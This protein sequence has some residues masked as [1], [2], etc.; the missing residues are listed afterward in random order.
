MNV[1]KKLEYNFKKYKNNNAFCINDINYTY[2]QLFI[3]VSQIRDIIQKNIPDQ[4]QIC[5]LFDYNDIETYATIIALWF[6]GK[7]YIPVSVSSPIERNSY[8][9]E[10]TSINFL[11]SSHSEENYIENFSVLSSNINSN[12][13]IKFKPYIIDESNLLYTIFTSGSTGLPKGVPI[14]LKNLNSLFSAMKFDE[15]HDIYPTDKCLQMFDLTFDYS[16]VTFL[17]PLLNGACVYTLPKDQI[18]Y[19]YI[20]KLINIYQLNYLIM[21]PS[22]INYL[23]PYFGEMNFKTVRYSCFGA[24][25]L[26]L[27]LVE[28]WKKCVPNAKI[29]NSYGPTENTVTSTYYDFNDYQNQ[30]SKNGIVAIGK[31]LKGIKTIILDTNN[32]IVKNGVEG[33]LCVSGNQVTVG[34]LNNTKKNKSSFIM[35]DYEGFN[36]KFYKTGDLCIKK[37]DETLIFIG[38]KDFQ[39]KI[40]GYRVELGEIEHHSKNFLKN[41]NISVIDIINKNNETEL[42]LII[43]NEEFDTKKLINY[44]KTKLPSY[45]IPTKIKFVK[46]LLYNSNGKIDNNKLKSLF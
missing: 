23:K 42:A 2:N 6:E 43:A 19:M 7:S 28:E 16:I 36:L 39:I 14:D 32:K 10:S 17:Y 24:A 33:E 15:R 46:E 1:L 13:L 29:Y 20:Y 41:N 3:K 26:P 34:Y 8:I 5:G 12:E 11:F 35:Y 30:I 31:P 22:I 25:P 37:D 38:R 9:F 45:M 44:L 27:N 40:G 21:V 18:K 4:E